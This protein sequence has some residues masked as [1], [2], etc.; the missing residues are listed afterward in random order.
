MGGSWEHALSGLA[1]ATGAP[2]A[3]LIGVGS[4]A[5]VPFNWITDLDPEALLEWLD[6]DG[7]DPRANARVRTGLLAREMADTIDPE[8]ATDEDLRSAV[9]KLYRKYGINQSCQTTLVRQPGFVVG[10]AVLQGEKEGPVQAPARRAFRTLAGHARAAI[11]L[12][13]AMEEQAPELIAGGFESVN[14]AAFICDR[15]GFVRALTP[16]AEKIVSQ[17]RHLSLARGRLKAATAKDE[18]R[19]ARAIAEAG[20][21]WPAIP[22][23]Q[24]LLIHAPGV[25][26]PLQLQVA[27]LPKR[28]HAFRFHAATLVVARAARAP[29][30]RGAML[31]SQYGLTPAET[32]IALA[33]ARGQ[34]LGEISIRRGVAVGTLRSQLKSVFGKLGVS[35]Q[36]QLAARVNEL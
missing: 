28:D 15:N 13:V 5:A 31:Q 21:P 36:A 27:P 11:A 12:Q 18:T 19:L 1:E 3:Q 17:Q 7:P 6:I 35:R 34:S 2:R 14:V 30:E 22:V 33:L 25:S 16:S 23:S 9:Y 10:M 24:E 29:D 32:E 20:A 8:F 26:R 4:D